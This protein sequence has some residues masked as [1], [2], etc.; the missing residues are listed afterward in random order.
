MVLESGIK[1]LDDF[2]KEKE[3]IKKRDNWKLYQAEMNQKDG[4]SS[5]PVVNQVIEKIFSQQE[6]GVKKYGTSISQA[7]LTLIEALEHDIEE[8]IDSLI[9]KQVAVNRLKEKGANII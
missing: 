8:N 7:N 5:D 4:L 1:T 9:Y 2:T 3:E 6:K